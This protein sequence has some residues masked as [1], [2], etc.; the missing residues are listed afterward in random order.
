MRKTLI[1]FCFCLTGIILNIAITRICLLTGIP[2][3]LDTT[4]T[5]SVTLICGLPWGILC[6]ALTN[7]IHHSI[8]G[9]GWEAYLF[10]ICNI[11]TAFITWYFYRFFKQELEGKQGDIPSA[12]RSSQLNR[13]MDK[14]I[15][16]ILFSFA[17]CLTMS[18]LGGLIATFI[19]YLNSAYYET[20]GVTGLLSATMFGHNVPVVFKEIVS[21]IPVN[22]I[23]RLISVFAGYGIAVIL[24]RISGLSKRV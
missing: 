4:F 23:D 12:R 18:I 21:R 8:W 1:M 14:V 13:I 24:K 16:L 6:G 22:I 19:L 7:I 5:I 17:L 15:I 3:W 10:S 2:L 20:D 9:Y 11:T